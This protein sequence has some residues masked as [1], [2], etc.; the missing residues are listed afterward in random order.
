MFKVAIVLDK[1]VRNIGHYEI[2]PEFSHPII[3]VDITNYQD[4]IKEGYI[5]DVETGNFTESLDTGESPDINT[6]TEP[7]PI[8]T[9]EEKIARLFTVT[10]QNNLITVDAVLGVYEEVLALREEVAALKGTSNNA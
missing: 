7:E 8:E 9:L 5:Y 3:V 2:L 1:V 4:I 10:E 6:P